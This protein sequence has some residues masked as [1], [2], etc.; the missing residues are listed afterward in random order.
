MSNQP[1]I[2]YIPVMKSH[3]NIARRHHAFTLPEMLA[4]ITIIAIL[5]SIALP[6]FTGRIV[7]K[8]IDEAIP[9]TDVAK[10]PI[11]SAWGSTQTFP[12][13]NAAAG[14]PSADKIVSNYVSAVAVQDGVINLTFGN[15]VH[16]ALAGK[17]L[18]IRPAVISDAPIVPITWVCG[19]ADVPDKMTVKGSD[20]TTVPE[21]YLPVGCRKLKH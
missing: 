9:L 5:A 21:T 10:K 14:L 13:D 15:S 7:R 18:T 17:I 4:V 20:Q 1:H 11:A 3:Q 6:S 12:R 2:R 19:K 16:G 8:Q